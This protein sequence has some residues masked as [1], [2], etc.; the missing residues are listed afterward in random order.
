[1]GLFRR[2]MQDSPKGAATYVARGA[3][4]KGTL[5]GQ[6]AFVF[7]GE[8]EGDCDI[9]GP[10]TLAEGARWVGTLKGADVIIAGTVEGDVIASRRVEIAGTAHISGSL[11]GH[12]IA[13][14]EGAV[15]DGELRVTSGGEAQRFEEK[16]NLVRDQADAA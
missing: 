5:Q 9:D 2:R 3:V 16:R 7:C 13:I 12:A 14:A 11:S 10:V 15:I 1:M 4:F 8:F 6:G